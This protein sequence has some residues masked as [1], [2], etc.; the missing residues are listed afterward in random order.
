[1]KRTLCLVFATAIVLG[2]GIGSAQAVEPPICFKSVCEPGDIYSTTCCLEWVQVSP[3]CKGPRCKMVE[4]W[5]C[6]QEPCYR[7]FLGSIPI[8]LPVPAVPEFTP[9]NLMQSALD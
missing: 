2:V 8:L 5:V 4:E 1:M 6:W 3:N 7:A 9:I